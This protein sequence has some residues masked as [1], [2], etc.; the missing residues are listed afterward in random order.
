MIASAPCCPGAARCVSEFPAIHLLLLTLAAAAAG[1]V[2]AIAGG[3]TLITF[4]ALLA[5]GL[6]PVA[7]NVTSTLALAP[8]YFGA[9]LAQRA[10]LAGRGAWLG[11][12]L[13][14]AALGG[15]AGAVLLLRGS[16]RAF[17]VLVPWLILTAAALIAA[18]DPVRRWLVSRGTRR[19]DAAAATPRDAAALARAALPVTAAAV[20]GGYFGAGL[21]V[22][23]LA[24]LGLALDDDFR[25]LNAAKQVIA[26][27]ANLAAAA[28]LAF[29]S[30]AAW[31]AVIAMALG[32]LA[33]GAAGGRFAQRI[34]PRRLRALIVTLGLAIGL[35][36]L[37]R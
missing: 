7:A 23:V 21:S 14:P 17:D 20:Y 15:A 37:W 30:R 32:A 33:G 10:D 6:P 9:T 4:P 22:I 29:S 1:A 31:P 3:G 36:Y 18:Q 8:G 16:E 34:D 24:V 5:A 28:C 2:N 13:P 19:L 26:F 11:F 35:V 25:R 27:A 12:L